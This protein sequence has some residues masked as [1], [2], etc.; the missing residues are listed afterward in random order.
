MFAKLGQ[1]G[2][3]VT[4]KSAD[5]IL[6]GDK[7]IPRINMG[8]RSLL[9]LNNVWKNLHPAVSLPAKLTVATTQSSRPVRQNRVKLCAVSVERRCLEIKLMLGT[10]D[11]G[12]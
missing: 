12:C 2:R 5:G 4:L 10:S 7:N 11:S 3:L 6:F 1:T 8:V 9:F